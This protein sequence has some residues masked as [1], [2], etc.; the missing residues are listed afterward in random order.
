MCLLNWN[1]VTINKVFCG[2]IGMKESYCFHQAFYGAQIYALYLTAEQWLTGHLITSF[3]PVVS[4]MRLVTAG[5]LHVGIIVMS[6][7]IN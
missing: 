5:E 3:I 2:C 4:C 6:P 7:F 1:I